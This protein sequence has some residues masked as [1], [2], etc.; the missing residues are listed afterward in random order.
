MLRVYGVGW[1]AIAPFD[2]GLSMY[3]KFTEVII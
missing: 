1:G 3:L 2:P